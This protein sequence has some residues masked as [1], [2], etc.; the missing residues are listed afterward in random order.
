MTTPPSFLTTDPAALVS[1]LVADFESATGR[2]LYPAQLERL[3]I[4]VSAY[5]ESLVR[6]AIQDAAEQ[7]LVEFARGVA[8]EARGALVGV[9]RL[10]AAKA[11]T[12]LRI[13]LPAVSGSDTAFA[14]GWGAI[15]GTAVFRLAASAVIPAGQLSVDAP[16]LAEP[17]GSAADGIP[18]GGG[19]TALEGA[20][21]VTSLEAS[22]GGADIEDDEALRTR[23]LEAPARFSCAGSAAGYRYHAMS[24]S[25]D[26]SAVAVESATPG[27]VAVYPLTRDGL[28]SQTTLDLVGAALAADTVRPICDSVS[29]LAPSRV[30]WSLDAT[31]TLYRQADAAG[32]LASAQAALDAYAADRRSGLGRDLVG[33]Q[34]LAALS[35]PGVYKVALNGWTDRALAPSEWADAGALT[36]HLAPERADG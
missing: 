28:P 5:R 27:V 29:V 36:L 3:L 10:P 33:S 25:P 13:T 17:A 32:V 22:S 15:N 18:A 2:T 9:S 7:C 24:A 20:V 1:A 35:V 4:N 30:A 8:L 21:T 31:L 16:A 11:A 6:L 12:T 14:A 26:I 19:W 34:I 23:I